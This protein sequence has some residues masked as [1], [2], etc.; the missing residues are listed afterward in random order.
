MAKLEAEGVTGEANG[1][2]EQQVAVAQQQAITVQGK[3]EAEAEQRI[4]VAQF[5]ANAVQGEND[6]KANIAD[7]KAT[8][9]ERRA[10]AKRRG[11][12]ALANA[13]RDVLIAEKER[14]TALLEKEQIAQQEIERKKIEIDAEAEAERQRR[15]ARGAADAVLAK[16]MAEAEGTR[17][18]LEAKAAGY[19]NLLRVC[20]E[21]KDL[22][23]ALLIIEKLPELVAEQVKAVQNLK[24][25]KVTVWDSGANGTE[26]GGATTQFLR[27]LIGALPPIHE[28]A[29]QAGIDLPD[30][31][32]KVRSSDGGTGGKGGADPA[33]SGDGE[34]AS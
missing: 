20:G 19:E 1:E 2:R 15:I 8:L 34:D 17:K 5:E 29:E 31:L 6:S 22:A 12:V 9:A 4:Q 24:I 11:D 21:R 28:L 26:G 7:Y 10:D 32:G 16:Y 30:V 25:D 23:P 33:G 18:L 27:G 14:E 3:K 13:T